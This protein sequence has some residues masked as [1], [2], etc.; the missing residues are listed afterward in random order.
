MA[1]AITIERILRDA[2]DESGQSIRDWKIEVE[3]EHVTIRPRMRD[4]FLLMR[5]ADIDVF[6][7]DLVRA[8]ETAKSMA[9]DIERS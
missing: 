2:D 7:V 8:K 9:K 6:M 1:L 5:A 4:G 3:G